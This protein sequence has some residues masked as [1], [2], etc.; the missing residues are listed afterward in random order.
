MIVHLLKDISLGGP[1]VMKYTAPVA[2]LISVEAV[3]VI[4]ASVEEDNSGNNMG[5]SDDL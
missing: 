1:F 3:S 5:G 4:L 2:E